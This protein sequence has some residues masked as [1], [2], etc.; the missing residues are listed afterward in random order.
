[1]SLRCMTPSPPLAHVAAARNPTGGVAQPEPH[2]DVHRR[3]G[4]R[5]PQ[6]CDVR[7]GEGGRRGC[8]RRRVQGHCRSHVRPRPQSAAPERPTRPQSRPL[9]HQTSRGSNSCS[10]GRASLALA[11]SGG[12]A[13][14]R[15][16]PIKALPKRL[17]F[18]GRGDCRIAETKAALEAGMRV[19]AELE[20]AARMVAQAASQA[21][22][23]IKVAA[24]AKAAA[25]QAAADRQC[26]LLH[27]SSPAAPPG[28][29]ATRQDR[30]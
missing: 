10:R 6:L 1:M 14:A 26:A 29:M 18:P 4:D 28:R 19:A 9:S 15:R 24:D 27:V 17:A 23:D 2:D 12:A 30:V 21:A 22:I 13:P 5:H 8:R 20:A 25:M 3:C 16:Y 11:S 7:Q